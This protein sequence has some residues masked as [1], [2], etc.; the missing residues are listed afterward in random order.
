M[1]AIL[2]D[3]LVQQYYTTHNKTY[4]DKVTFVLWSVETMRY[5]GLMEAQI[6][7]LLGV[8]PVRSMGRVKGFEVIPLKNM[9]HP[10]Y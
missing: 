4:P 1:G 6:Y 8:K 10:I 2:G 7:S 9:N 5:H 3:Q